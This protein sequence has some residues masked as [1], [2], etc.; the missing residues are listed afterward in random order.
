MKTLPRSSF[1]RRWHRYAIASQDLPLLGFCFLWTAT[2]FYRTALRHPLMSP[3][4]A[5]VTEI[6]KLA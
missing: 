3:E 4:T 1:V 2:Q 5:K 6:V